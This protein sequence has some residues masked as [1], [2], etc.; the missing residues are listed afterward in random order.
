[1]AVFRVSR[2][3][4]GGLPYRDTRRV[5]WRSPTHGVRCA[6]HDNQWRDLLA[7][8]A[9]VLR[10]GAAFSHQTAAQLLGLPLPARFQ[11]MQSVHVTVPVGASRGTRQQVVW[12]RAP[13]AD[14][15]IT[16]DG[17]RVTDAARTWLDLGPHLNLPQ[18]VAVTD[19]IL[20]RQLC[21][22][23]A[24]PPRARGAL[25]LRQAVELADPR[26]C[27]PEESQLRVGLTLAGLPKPEVNF[28]VIVH[29][30]W[31]GRGDLVWPEYMLYLEYDGGHHADPG[32]RH[33]DAQTRNRLAQLGWRV[34]V[35]T[36]SMR[37]HDVVEM[38]TEDLRA[39]GW[40]G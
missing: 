12:H 36:S 21:S 24:V 32:Q 5:A 19:V 40:P 34:R 2:K 13:I 33:Q 6:A 11:N 1:M 10:T 25:R 39:A 29:G 3:G 16:A 22:E 8:I 17:F 23:L 26:S 4:G 20:R 37:T 35:V 27:S 14:R 7:A 30:E 18:L 38:V 9:L 15:V 28:D 31:I